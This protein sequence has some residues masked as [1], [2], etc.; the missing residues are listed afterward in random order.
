MGNLP[1]FDVLVGFT[2]KPLEDSLLGF[3]DVVLGLKELDF[4]GRFLLGVTVGTGNIPAALPWPKGDVVVDEGLLGLGVKT[5][6]SA[7]AAAGTRVFSAGVSSTTFTLPVG[8]RSGR[9]LN[10]VSNPKL[11]ANR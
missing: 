1:G 10:L 9:V 8:D 2:G 6:G 5:K 7:L 3:L 11:L 4:L